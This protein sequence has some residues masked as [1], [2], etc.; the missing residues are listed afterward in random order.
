MANLLRKVL[1]GVDRAANIIQQ[2]FGMSD[3]MF[4]KT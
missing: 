4:S 1:R 3:V 2:V